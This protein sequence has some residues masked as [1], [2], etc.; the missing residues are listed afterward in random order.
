MGILFLKFAC[1]PS[2]WDTLLLR[3]CLCVKVLEDFT[4][5]GL[6]VRQAF[7]SFRQACTSGGF[8]NDGYYAWWVS[9][10]THRLSSRLAHGS[11]QRGVGAGRSPP[12]ICNHN[13]GMGGF[14]KKLICFPA[15]LHKWGVGGAQPP[16]LQTYCSHGEWVF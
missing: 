3:A 11:K 12:P 13:A 8:Q 5:R 6:P 9:P 10:T 16:R 1:A 15:S 2:Y 14:I 4:F 7:G